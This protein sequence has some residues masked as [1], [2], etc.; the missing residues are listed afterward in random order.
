MEVVPAIYVER[1]VSQRRLHLFKAQGQVMLS[2]KTDFPLIIRQYFEDLGEIIYDLENHAGLKRAFKLCKAAED[3][4]GGSIQS[5]LKYLPLGV[6]QDEES[7][8][9]PEAL[10]VGREV[11]QRHKESAI[12]F[13]FARS[14]A[15]LLINE[16]YAIIGLKDRS[17]EYVRQVNDL[18]KQVDV[19]EGAGTWT[20]L[21]EQ[22]LPDL[23]DLNAI[24]RGYRSLNDEEIRSINPK[25]E[26]VRRLAKLARFI[27]F[28]KQTRTA[29][30]RA[31]IF[32][33][34]HHDVVASDIV[35]R[36]IEATLKDL[37]PEVDALS[38]SESP[39]TLRFE[40][41]IK[42]RIWLCDIFVGILPADTFTIGNQ[43]DKNYL[44]IARETEHAL[45]LGK[46]VIFLCEDELKDDMVASDFTND[47]MGF[48]ATNARPSGGGQWTKRAE[49]VWEHYLESARGKFKLNG[50]DASAGSLDSRSKNFILEAAKTA[51][52]ERHDGLLEALQV[53]YSNDSWD[54]IQRLHRLDPPIKEVAKKEIV[55]R[56]YDSA[57]ATFGN[58][59]AA[60]AIFESAWKASQKRKLFF[61]GKEHA[62]LVRPKH[63]F[64]STNIKEIMRNLRPDFS[65][66]Q[67][68]EWLVRFLGG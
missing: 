66:D 50:I 33:S 13:H 51:V 30:N 60:E 22:R 27:V 49:R 7:S 16:I 68:Q 8:K 18:P 35:R 61:N 52:K 48:L 57:P 19:L 64:Y 43:R 46:P 28:L 41:L 11:Y 3:T 26:W 37:R 15:L 40:K 45:L 23:N 65:E 67:I 59:Q 9:D 17:A 6:D 4:I 32:L 5:K 47:H 36:Q 56:L 39:V 29:P 38:V 25:T 31:R 53:Q 63:G 62:A 55:K 24:L 1:D 54:T 14:L 20:D 12:I 2:L 10:K 44:W 42:A 21:S 58:L 34:Y